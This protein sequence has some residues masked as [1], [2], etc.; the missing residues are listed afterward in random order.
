MFSFASFFKPLS[1]ILPTNDVNIRDKDEERNESPTIEDSCYLCPPPLTRQNACVLPRN[2][3]SFKSF[4]DLVTELDASFSFLSSTS[5]REKVMKNLQIMKEIESRLFKVIEGSRK[6]EAVSLKLRK[7][8]EDYLSSS[9]DLL[10][11]CALV[12]ELTSLTS[13]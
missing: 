3:T 12:K 8:K 11:F 5:E 13:V 6:D 2:F 9:M 4:D 1:A 7:L 10:V